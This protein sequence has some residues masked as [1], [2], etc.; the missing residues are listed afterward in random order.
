[1]RV[2]RSIVTLGWVALPLA[3][4]VNMTIVQSNT[5]LAPN[6]LPPPGS[7]SQGEEIVRQFV[8]LSRSTTWKL[9]E[10]VK[11][12]GNT[13]EPEGIVR[14]G[15]NRYFVSAGEYTE[16]TV[17]YNTT[18]N[19]TDRTAGQG[20]G[21]MIV[22]DGKG[23]RIA[24]ASITQ[25]GSL[26]Y[27][28]GGIDYD[29]TYIWA[30]LAQYR[31]NSTATLIRMDPATLEPEAML[32][33]ADHQGGAIH[34]LSTGNILT[35]NWGSRNAS[36]W[37]LNYRP[38]VPPA[39]TAPRAVIK[40]PSHYTDYQDCKFLGHSKHYEFRPVML[41]SGIT[42]IYNTTI[43]GVAIVDMNTMVPLYE[44][45]LT[46]VSDGGSLVTKNPMD[47]AVVDDKLRLFFLP[48]EDESTLYAYEAA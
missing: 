27:H 8:D 28:N 21:H 40:N 25:A 38:S 45:P 4:A 19:G 35:L 1:M 41:C 42:G 31:P 24:D 10:K 12:Q 14:I 37:N 7:S 30:T 34:D 2:S 39:F 23:N 3:A 9:V 15:D 46:M 47:V 22:F 6:P 20:F 29:G 17:K 26:E 36:I 11:F 16:K 13:Y 44:V 18:M 32:H 43:G 48:D 33:I 5:T